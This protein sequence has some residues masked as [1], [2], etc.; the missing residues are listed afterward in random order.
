MKFYDT[1]RH[2]PFQKSQDGL[3]NSLG[4]P[5]QLSLERLCADQAGFELVAAKQGECGLTVGYWRTALQ[6]IG[7]SWKVFRK[8]GPRV[9]MAFLNESVLGRDQA[10]GL[11]NGRKK[12]VK[13]KQAKKKKATSWCKHRCL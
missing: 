12:G 10:C 5:D 11:V 1:N 6:D 8:P 4:T 2:K 13:K 3:E 9:G 7:L